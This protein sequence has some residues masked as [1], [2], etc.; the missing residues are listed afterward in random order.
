MNKQD[1]SRAGDGFFP[2][3]GQSTYYSTSL[4]VQMYQQTFNTLIITLTLLHSRLLF[5]IFKNVQQ[6]IK[7]SILTDRIL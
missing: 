2:S 4:N 7:F 6:E 5:A 3:H 1:D